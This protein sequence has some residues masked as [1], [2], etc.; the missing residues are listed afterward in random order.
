MSV[1]LSPRGGHFG[2]FCL[3]IYT[4]AARFSN[5][6]QSRQQRAVATLA[7]MPASSHVTDTAPL[8][9]GWREWI[10]LP[11]LGVARLKAKVDT[12]A[13]TSSLHAF[14][15]APFQNGPTLWVRFRLHPKQY[16]RDIEVTCEAPVK[17]RRVVIDS[18]GHEELRY[19]VE[20][21]V[22][23]ANR[24]WPIEITL[25]DRDDMRFR[26]LLGRT[27][28]RGHA[29]V[30]PDRSFLTRRQSIDVGRS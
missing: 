15:V 6:T 28:I 3:F 2:F 13:R 20:T 30:D 17:D 11:D 7:D 1:N 19:V 10:G 29:I 9:L 14:E 18:G 16:R 23:I 27:A 25:A 12:G 26:M 4:E 21:R 22:R 8:M 24:V 5:P